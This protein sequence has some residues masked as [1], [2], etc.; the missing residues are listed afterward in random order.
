M[1]TKFARAPF[2]HTYTPPK[3][4]SYCFNPSHHVSKRPFIR[5]YIIDENDA[6]NSHYEHDK[7]YFST[8]LDSEEIV[9][10]HEEEEKEEQ[11]EHPQ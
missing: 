5:Y 9:D 1:A 10:N 6:S 2:S 11:V 8:T 7:T 3:S 4:Y